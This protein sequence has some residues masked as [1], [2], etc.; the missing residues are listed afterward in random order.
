MPSM[1]V[2]VTPNFWAGILVVVL[3]ILGS[4]ASMVL[5]Y[6]W[7]DPYR[8]KEQRDKDILKGRLG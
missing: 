4:I 1:N 5:L 3:T 8:T 2:T 7:D 6:N